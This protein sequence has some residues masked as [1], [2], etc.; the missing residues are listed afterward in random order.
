MTERARVHGYA[1][2]GTPDSTLILSA[3]KIELMYSAYEMLSF[4]GTRE[5]RASAG[6]DS[7]LAC[8]QA[9]HMLHYVLHCSLATARY[10]LIAPS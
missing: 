7:M 4:D 10:S 9:V 8:C 2:C 5:R 3:M 6:K 1:T